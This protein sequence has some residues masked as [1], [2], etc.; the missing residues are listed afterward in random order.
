M[1]F[2]FHFVAKVNEKKFV[3][4]L[5]IPIVCSKVIV[6]ILQSTPSIALACTLSAVVFNF[7]CADSTV[8]LMLN[9]EN[10]M[11]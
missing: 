10:Y 8:Q 5:K 2:A 6:T 4:L 1:L 11:L 7:F 3:Y 9:K